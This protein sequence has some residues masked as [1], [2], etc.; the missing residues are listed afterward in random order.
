M[1]VCL[2]FR[3]VPD[4]YQLLLPGLCPAAAVDEEAESHAAEGVLEGRVNSQISNDF[5]WHLLEVCMQINP[6]DVLMH[7]SSDY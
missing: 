5:V 7:P 4:Y 1:P 2:L 6:T 3:H